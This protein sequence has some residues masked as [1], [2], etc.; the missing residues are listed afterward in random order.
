MVRSTARKSALLLAPFWSRPQHVGRQRVERFLRWLQNAGWSIVLVR[1]GDRDVVES[2]PWGLEISIRDPLGLHRE[3]SQGGTPSCLKKEYPVWI[4]Y[5]A[6]LIFNP[7]PGIVWARRVIGNPHIQEAARQAEWILAS[8]PPESAHV[9]ARFLAEQSGARLLVDMR[10]GWLDEP[11]KDSL[12]RS[13]VR[14]WR[15]GRLERRVLESADR[16]TV[17]SSLWRELLS[18]RYPRWAEKVSVLPNCY[19]P[20]GQKSAEGFPASGRIVLLHAGQFTGSKFNNRPELL[21]A[22]IIESAGSEL[23]AKLSVNLRGRFTRKDL[24]EI[25]FWQKR[26]RQWGADL[27]IYPPV[28]PQELAPLL[29]KASGLLLLSATRASIVAKLFDYLPSR[30]PILAVTPEGSSI[31]KIAASVPQMFSVNPDQPEAM[32]KKVREFLDACQSKEIDSAVPEEFTEQ[33][34]E[35]IFLELLSTSPAAVTKQERGDILQPTIARAE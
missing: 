20:E 35:K 16:I 7:D 25:K 1:A 32:Q 19:P 27:A 2:A 18:E 33:F 17:T 21:L 14:R 3:V 24:K 9:A 12:N 4:R 5:A 31:W 13:S 15:E 28:S 34:Q 30:R 10:D 8:S 23:G 11:L 26:Y 6:Y 29:R 22:P